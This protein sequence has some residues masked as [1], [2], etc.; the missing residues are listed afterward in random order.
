MGK[1]VVIFLIAF[2]FQCASAQYLGP[3]Y[4]ELT[5]NPSAEDLSFLKKELQTARVVMLGEKT[6]ADGNVYE[7]KIKILKYLQSEMGFNTVAFESGTYDLWQAQKNIIAG[8][9]V[10][11]ALASS[12]YPIWSKSEQFS[13]FTDFFEQHKSVMKLYGFDSQISGEL[14]EKKLV[15]GL[16]EYCRRKKIRLDLRQEDLELLV[17][18]M[19]I[20]GIYDGGD[21]SYD[22]YRKAM[23]NVASH[24][25]SL[26]E[27]EENFYWVQII[28]SLLATAQGY[29]NDSY[30]VSSFYTTVDDNTRDRQMSENLLEYIRMHPDEKIVCWGANQHFVNSMASV[31]TPVLKD[32]V[33]MGTF[34]KSAL[35]NK[36]YSLAAV[37]AS[38][39][40]YLENSWRAT[41]IEIGSF[42]HQLKVT[43]KK[44]L[45]VSSSQEKMSV[46]IMS[47]LFSPQTFVSARLDQLHDGY[48]FFS[49]VTP[50]VTV[51]QQYGDAVQILKKEQE[52][53]PEN[54]ANGSRGAGINLDEVI[55][56]SRKS[57]NQIVQSAI[58]GIDRNYPRTP[59]SSSGSTVIE[60]QVADTVRLNMGIV[61]SQYDFSYSANIR[62]SKSIEWIDYSVKNGYEPKNLREFHSLIYNNP[63]QYAPF[64]DI[65]KSKK[66]AF[67]LEKICQY[68]G[69]EAYVISFSTPKK[70]STFTRRMFESDYRGLIYIDKEDFAV[71]KTIEIWEIEKFPDEFAQGFSF[72]G[73][74]TKFDRK[75]FDRE[76]IETEFTRIGKLYYIAGSE[77]VIE[78]KI[79][80]EKKMR[81][82]EGF[83]MK[84]KSVWS[85]FNTENAKEI[86]NK[87]EKHLFDKIKQQE[88]L[89]AP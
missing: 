14:G 9:S 16:Y 17:E 56:Y 89:R 67:E 40:I 2:F 62:S 27:T 42:E 65:K 21:I 47:R 54:K 60:M 28:K 80:D 49:S 87:Q 55:V 72:S 45:F 39:S 44:H 81:E 31:S 76:K 10:E 38:D 8:Q 11:K 59:F 46:P 50:S 7:M 78:G 75:D 5:D 51:E 36:V 25:A 52:Q 53:Q 58:R 35:G 84:I 30:T 63:I 24:M 18:S 23:L 70:H 48:L 33:P 64:L 29:R 20:S 74:L 22:A 26:P 12:L 73:S 19:A 43:G 68:S 37:T 86:T 3:A 41:P 34:V 69:K 82:E 57:V 77:I 71:L 88:K 66:F 32:F 85:D 13:E 79:G 4:L 15:G 1:N 83:T 61:F 6:H